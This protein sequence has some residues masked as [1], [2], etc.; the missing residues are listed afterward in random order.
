MWGPDFKAKMIRTQKQLL[1]D[2][3]KEFIEN[4][5]TR[6]HHKSE[7]EAHE[8]PVVQSPISV[9]LPSGETQS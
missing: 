6:K 1:E 7:S 5:K 8:T 9:G 4:E 3:T 2:M